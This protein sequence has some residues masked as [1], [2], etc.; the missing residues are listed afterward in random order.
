MGDFGFLRYRWKDFEAEKYLRG[1]F[2]FPP[3]VVHELPGNT[4]IV[5]VNYYAR[6][7]ECTSVG[8][9]IT[10]AQFR[11]INS[12]AHPRL[13]IWDIAGLDSIDWPGPLLLVPSID[14]QPTEA[15][16][17]RFVDN[18]AVNHAVDFT[19]RTAVVSSL[20]SNGC[21][22]SDY[23]FGNEGALAYDGDIWGKLWGMLDAF[24]KPPPFEHPAGYVRDTALF[25]HPLKLLHRR[26]VEEYSHLAAEQPDNAL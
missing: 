20:F 6:D 13:I 11:R 8:A 1:P 23:R 18:L 21:V 10:S 9:D 26:L 25:R 2:R 5:A 7:L 16:F 12:C 24:I 15:Q 17:Q 19:D 3:K 14:L 22:A 4:P